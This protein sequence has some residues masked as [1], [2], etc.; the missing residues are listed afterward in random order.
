MV[1]R[2]IRIA[3]IGLLVAGSGLASTGGPAGATKVSDARK[4]AAMVPA[5]SSWTTYHHDNG[6]TGYDPAAPAAGT[7]AATPGWTQTTLD[8]EVYA[9]PLVYAGVVYAATLNNTVYAL[10]Q[11]DGTEL[12]HKNLGAPVTGGWC[13]GN[14]SPQGILGTGVVDTVANRI[15]VAT[16][17]NSTKHY[18]LF[19]LDLAT[20]GTLV[21]QTDLTVATG[22]EWTIQQ[23]RGALSLANGN[24]YVPFGGRWGDCG[25][26]HGYV[27]GAPT[28]GTGVPPF[29]QTPSSGSGIWAAGGVVVDDAATNN[30]FAAT[31]NG[32]AGGCGSVNQ[33]D[34]VVRLA[35]T[36]LAMQDYFMPNDW[37]TW[38]SNDEDLGSAGPVLLSPNLIFQAG[39]Q[40]GGFLLDPNALG[41][42]DGQLF[43][44]P[45]PAGYSQA[46]VCLGN[47]HDATFG[48]FAYAAP[49]VYLECEGH[50]I[51]ALHV[52]TAAKTFVPCGTGCPA[53]DWHALDGTTFGPPIVAGGAVWAATDGGGLYAFNATTGAQLYHSAGFGINRFVTPA[54]ANGQVF[55]PAKTVIKSFSFGTPVSPNDNQGHLYTLDGYGGL[56]PDGSAPALASASYWPGWSIARS[57]TLFPDA[58]GGYLMDGYG[59]LHEVG[60]ATPVNGFA[61]WGG[62]DIARQVVLAPWSSRTSPAGWTLD[63]LGGVHPFGGAPDVGPTARWDWDIARSLVIL[64]DSTPSSVAGYTLDGYGGVHP[65]GG[66]PAISNNAYW[67]WDI[68]R[69]FTPSPTATKSNPA[70][71]SVDG[72]GGVHPFGSAPAYSNYARWDWDIGRGIVAWNGG[73]GG[74]VLDGWGGIHP[75]GT[76]PNIPGFAYW[77]GWD[78]ATSLTGANF[79][80]SSMHR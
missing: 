64:P 12:W 70:G 4:S 7:I 24:V 49:Y 13:N 57:V 36:T 77:P 34:A 9:E 47:H 59:G 29:Y 53:P 62:W 50:G 73:T 28:S 51:V 67:G 18:Y 80:T 10:R 55:V 43:P 33:N 56:H 72:Y 58:L 30:V 8:G 78:I 32:V 45:K 60:N 68:A 21:L 31:G 3:A 14:V 19:G 66:A 27:V 74:W 15:Y 11:S 41:G 61:Y 44:T 40:G 65:F 54:E 35:P 48:S 17:L 16:I 69:G 22:M 20:S 38:C 52:D 39:K 6:H 25:T 75:F 2:L 5:G 42:V 26:Y 1:S 46:D 37:G 76:A 23:Q 79:G 63:G 71:W